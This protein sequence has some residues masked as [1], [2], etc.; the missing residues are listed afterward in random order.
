[1]SPFVPTFSDE[2][3]KQLNLPTPKL[4][5]NTFSFDVPD[6]HGIGDSITPLIQQVE[7][8]RIIEWWDRYGSYKLNTTHIEMKVGLI[9]DVTEH[10]QGGE[11]FV[12]TVNVG[13]KDDIS[14]VARIQHVYQKEDLVNTKCVVLTNLKHSNFQGVPSQ[15]MILG[16]QENGEGGAYGLVRVVDD[17][18]CHPGSR[19]L[20]EGWN[21]KPQANMNLKE[22]QKQKFYT[23]D[24]GSV[25]WD[26][27]KKKPEFKKQPVKNPKGEGKN[28][29]APKQ[30]QNAGPDIVP[31]QLVAVDVDGRVFQ[32]RAEKVAKHPATIK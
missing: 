26:A 16:A 31:R 19:V 25:W 3:S 6:G 9:K 18:D 29:A 14:I 11:K 12:L 8:E 21:C 2:L 28:K 1:M 10:P 4:K 13:S 20:P 22:F 15:G 5:G 32:V 30:A 7:G 27:E 24:D 17:A 23:K